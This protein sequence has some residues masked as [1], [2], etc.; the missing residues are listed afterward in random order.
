MLIQKRNKGRNLL[1]ISSPLTLHPL[2]LTSHIATRDPRRLYRLQYILPGYGQHAETSD[3][4]CGSRVA[5]LL[6]D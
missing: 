5:F 6:P 3:R 4:R 1:P 2:H